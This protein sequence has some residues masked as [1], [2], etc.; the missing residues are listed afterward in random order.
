MVSSVWA[1]HFARYS[2]NITIF[3][4]HKIVV[5]VPKFCQK[6]LKISFTIVPVLEQE[7]H[8]CTTKNAK[9]CLFTVYEKLH[10]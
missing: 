10:N 2:K 1:T 9:N 3:M 8:Y 4:G 7:E 6:N 5:I